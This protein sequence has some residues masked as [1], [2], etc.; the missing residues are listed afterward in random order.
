MNSPDR[1]IDPTRR[2]ARPCVR[3]YA[4]L[5]AGG[6]RATGRSAELSG[7]CCRFEEYGHTLF[8][9]APEAEMLLADAPPPVRPL[10]DG[11]DLPL[12]GR[13]G[14]A[15][16]PAR[17]GPWAVGVYYCDHAYPGRDPRGTR[18][19]FHCGRLKSDRL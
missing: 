1:P 4:E 10:D 7:R 19:A 15:A 11:A 3:L 18:R 8:L 12:A 14:A 5:D 17:P 16:P 6:R 13:T 9:S 2:S